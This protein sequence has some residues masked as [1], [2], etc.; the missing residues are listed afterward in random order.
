[1]GAIDLNDYIVKPGKKLD[2]ADRSTKEDAGLTKDDVN[3]I[4]VPPL[5]QEQLLLRGDIDALYAFGPLDA[6][7]RRK[8]GYRQLFKLSDL[9]GR[10]IIRGGTMA[11]EDFIAKNPE[12][13][14][15]YTA[16]IAKAADWANAN[17]AGVVQI[18]IDQGRIDKDLAPWIG[19]SQ[20]PGQAIARV[21]VA[22]LE[23]RSG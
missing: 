9:T 8:G 6:Q 13:V 20:D 11:K 19:N 1:M 5:Q 12:V 2:L 23:R 22:V 15:R 14:R 4:A 21:P 18:G 10:R 17:P 16:A 3:Y 7:L